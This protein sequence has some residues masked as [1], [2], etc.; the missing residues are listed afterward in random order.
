[1]S[2]RDR[3]NGQ[4]V[5]TFTYD[6]Y[7]FYTVFQL[8]DKFAFAILELKRN[9]KK[10]EEVRIQIDFEGLH[11]GKRFTQSPVQIYID[12]NSRSIEWK[13]LRESQMKYN[14]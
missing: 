6:M 3:I 5:R 4:C 2:E 13:C 7:I 10:K 1:M 12:T 14:T 9:I 11:F 8:L